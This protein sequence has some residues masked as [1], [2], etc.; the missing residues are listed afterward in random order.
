MTFTHTVEE[1][2]EGRALKYHLKTGDTS[3]SFEEAIKLLQE[4]ESFRETL[5]SLL[6]EAPYKT[7]RWECPGVS[8]QQAHQRF[9]F[10]LIDHPGL[11]AMVDPHAFREHFTSAEHNHGVVA[12]SNLGGD[13]RLVVPSPIQ[14]GDAFNH[15]AK[16]MRTASLAQVHAVWQTVG[17]EMENRLSNRPVWLSTAGDGV[18]WLHIRLDDRPKYYRYQ[19]YRAI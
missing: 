15:L 6:R 17:K 11:A 2:Y 5:I 14:K 1:L 8:R 12:F 13:A 4:N 10:V 19:P 16:F 3:L 7:Y 9:E 18:S